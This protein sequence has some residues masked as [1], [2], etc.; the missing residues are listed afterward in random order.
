VAIYKF[1]PTPARLKE[2]T[3]LV[4]TGKPRDRVET[5][6]LLHLEPKK[7]VTNRRLRPLCRRDSRQTLTKEVVAQRFTHIS[8]WQKE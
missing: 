7:V 5:F 8:G 6:E 1:I 3:L 2:T 4:Q